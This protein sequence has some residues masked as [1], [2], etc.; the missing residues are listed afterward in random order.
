[1]SLKRKTRRLFDFSRNELGSPELIRQGMIP[2]YGSYLEIYSD[3][4]RR[5]EL[6]RNGEEVFSYRTDTD[7]TTN[8]YLHLTIVFDEI[9]YIVKEEIYKNNDFIRGFI[10][11]SDTNKQQARRIAEQVLSNRKQS[12]HHLEVTYLPEL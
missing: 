4:S 7:Q 5:G 10:Y 6:S 8:D 1:M 11:Y 9:N 2:A 3:I 12:G